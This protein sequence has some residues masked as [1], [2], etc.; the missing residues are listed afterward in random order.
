MALGLLFTL[1]DS[2]PPRGARGAQLNPHPLPSSPLPAALASYL[3]YGPAIAEHCILDA[4]LDPSAKL[5]KVCT[6]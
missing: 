6:L 1:G 2:A 4:G 5:Q 3:P